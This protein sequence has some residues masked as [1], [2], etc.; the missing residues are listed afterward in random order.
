MLFARLILFAGAVALTSNAHAGPLD[1]P[2]G[3]VAPSGPTL[4]EV[5]D[6]DRLADIV[7]D[8][9][10]LAGALSVHESRTDVL[11]LPGD[12]LNRHIISEPGSYFLSA[13]ILV[14]DNDVTGV[15]INADHVTLDL[16]GKTIM[17]SATGDNAA[18][19]G[20]WGVYAESGINVVV[21][22]G[23]VVDFHSGQV[24]INGAMGRF[25]SIS[26]S[27]GEANAVVLTSNTSSMLIGCRV[28]STENSSTG[29]SLSFTSYGYVIADSHARQTSNFAFWLGNAAAVRDCS[30]TGNTFNDAFS[31]SSGSVLRRCTSQNSS[32]GGFVS[33]PLGGGGSIFAD[34]SAIDAGTN[35]FSVYQVL[36]VGCVATAAGENGYLLRSASSLYRCLALDSDDDGFLIDGPSSRVEACHAES[37]GAIPANYGFRAGALGSRSF[38]VRNTAA[39]AFDT[40]NNGAVNASIFAPDWFNVTQAG[41][42]DNLSQ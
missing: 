36:L 4:L 35:G 1:P 31:V 32:S 26:A 15:L 39:G 40:F 2:P 18:L 42:W 20:P 24:R 7:D 33:G 16:C 9:E 23:N 37:V 10:Q 12:A 19:P 13:D 6:N 3:P 30:A 27:G 21:R 5:H 22:N 34:C 28:D 14:S 25:E 41:P 29:F 11:T 38:V 17:S 8:I